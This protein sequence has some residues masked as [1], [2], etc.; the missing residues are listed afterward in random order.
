MSRRAR[1]LF[2]TVLTL[3]LLF[4]FLQVLWPETLCSFERLHIFG[5][6]LLTGG[7]LILYH[8]QGRG[9]LTRRVKTYFAL[10][11]LYALFA[12]FKSYVPALILSVPLFLTVE[13]VR[14]QRFSL[15]P[16]DF[17]RR[18]PVGE[19]FN[20][21]SLLCLSIGILVASLV[22]LNNEYWNLVH[23][24]KLTI[25]VF[26]L[27]YS[28]PVSLITMSIMFSFMT[29]RE[30]RLITALKEI[31]FWSVNLGVIVFFAMIIFELDI[32][33]MMVATTL[34]FVV[35]MIFFLFLATAPNVQQKTFLVS[36][37]VFLLFTALTGIFYILPYFYPSLEPYRTP[38]LVV[39]AMVSLYGWNLSGLFII[40]R[41]GQFPIRLRAALAIALHWAIVLVLAPLGILLAPKSEYALPVSILAVVAYVLLLGIVLA[42]DSQRMEAVG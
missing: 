32:P 17:F 30:G 28:F 19:K 7:S 37:M 25:E 41:W 13:S 35:W 8:T 14:V 18:V 2:G 16:L 21:A 36:G 34:F 39:H 42:G 23:Y 3:A 29:E 40:M 4:G 15:L 9:V 24:E 31:G 10:A 22:I 33:E 1:L 11:L 5:F 26:F 20:Q 6:N 27:G 12:A 38:S